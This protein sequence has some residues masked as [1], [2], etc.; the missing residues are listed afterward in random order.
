M[1]TTRT[2][3]KLIEWEPRLSRPAGKLRLR[4]LNQVEEDL[5]EMKV[6]NWRE[7]FKDRRLERNRKAGQNPPRVIAP[8]EGEEEC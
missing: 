1:D 5:K 8:V 3:K 2:V 4:W 6:K 7:M